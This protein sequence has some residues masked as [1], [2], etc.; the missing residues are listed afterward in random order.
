MLA[1]LKKVDP[2]QRGFLVVSLNKLV[3]AK[4]ETPMYVICIH[5]WGRWFC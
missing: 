2:K 4:K 1:F 3:P 5:I